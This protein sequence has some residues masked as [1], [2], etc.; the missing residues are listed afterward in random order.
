MAISFVVSFGFL[1]A[2][3]A[4]WGASILLNIPCY[5]VYFYFTD[6]LSLGSNDKRE[7]ICFCIFTNIY[8]SS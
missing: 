1:E 3:Q 5:S 8:P 7:Q 6:I 2:Y 4:V